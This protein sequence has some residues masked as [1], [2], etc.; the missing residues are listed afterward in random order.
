MENVI[1]KLLLDAGVA[2][3]ACAVFLIMT[4]RN[5][6]R[7]ISILSSSNKENSDNLA[8]LIAVSSENNRLQNQVYEALKPSTLIQAQNLSSISFDYAALRV[9]QI[10]LEVKSQNHLKDESGTQEKING[11]LKALYKYI[12]LTFTVFQYSGKALD[13]YLTESWWISV[14][15]TVHDEVYNRDTKN[16]S[17]RIK[18]NVKSA[19]DIIENDFKDKLNKG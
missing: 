10:I 13:K 11:Q 17:E 7:F 1:V 12:M 8:K 18:K 19:F 2:V 14:A 6:N 16:S 5:N 3:A 15:K 4:F 9:C